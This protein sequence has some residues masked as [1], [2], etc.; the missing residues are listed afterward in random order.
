MYALT[1]ARSRSWNANKSKAY[2]S[3]AKKISP[4]AVKQKTQHRQKP[5][6]INTGGKKAS[7]QVTVHLNGDPARW[8]CFAHNFSPKRFSAPFF[9]CKITSDRHSR[10]LPSGHLRRSVTR[11]SES[12]SWQTNHGQL[13]RTLR[14]KKTCKF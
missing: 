12:Q 1:S 7:L 14:Y 4:K 9:I 5:K 11:Q 13:D 6:R 8:T 3:S 10:H 2:L